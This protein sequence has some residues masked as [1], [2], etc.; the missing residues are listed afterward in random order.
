LFNTLR[1]WIN[2]INENINKI[3]LKQKKSWTLGMVIQT[4]R[5]SSHITCFLNMTSHTCLS[6]LKKNMTSSPVIKLIS[7]RYWNHGSATDDRPLYTAICHWF[8]VPFGRWTG[9]IF[10]YPNKKIKAA[11]GRTYI[12]TKTVIIQPFKVINSECN[13][14]M[15]F[16]VRED[17]NQ[18]M[19]TSLS[20]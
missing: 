13:L 9:T 19:K 3:K 5:S 2:N 14:K 6:N 7:Q 16:E 1:Y 18:K 17:G 10:F 15:L 12:E 20:G 11:A 8:R 4:G